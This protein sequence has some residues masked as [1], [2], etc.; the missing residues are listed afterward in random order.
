MPELVVGF[1]VGTAPLEKMLHDE[2]T[3]PNAN[4]TP[5]SQAAAAS[6][7]G[8]GSSTGAANATSPQMF[9]VQKSEFGLRSLRLSFVPRELSALLSPIT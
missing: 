6:G 5:P 9:A 3:D 1:S 4:S 2:N 8:G 7:G